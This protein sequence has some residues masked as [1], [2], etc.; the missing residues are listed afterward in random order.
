MSTPLSKRERELIKLAV[1]DPLLGLSCPFCGGRS[2]TLVNTA[3]LLCF[4]CGHAPRFAVGALRERASRYETAKGIEQAKEKLIDPVVQ[5]EAE[6]KKSKQCRNKQASDDLP[7]ES[8]FKEF[9]G[10][11]FDF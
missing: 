7:K 4:K 2:W 8:R 3:T 6:A 10:R 1:N 5:M 11:V 9:V